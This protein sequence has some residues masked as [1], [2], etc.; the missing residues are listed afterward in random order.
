M[1]F[2]GIAGKADNNLA[3]LRAGAGVKAFF[4][5]HSALRV[6]YRFTQYRGT[7]TIDV[8]YYFIGTDAGSRDIRIQD[9][10]VQVGISLW[11]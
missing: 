4:G 6:E 1:E 11:L 3:L 2:F 10:K 8:P 9:H 5:R 7:D